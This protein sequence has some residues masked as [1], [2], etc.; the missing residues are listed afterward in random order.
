MLFIRLSVPQVIEISLY[1]DLRQS[2]KCPA[3]AQIL[4]TRVPQVNQSVCSFRMCRAHLF[5]LAKLPMHTM[6]MRLHLP[7]NIIALVLSCC[8]KQL[9]V[10][11]HR[12]CD[13]WSAKEYEF[14]MVAVTDDYNYGAGRAEDMALIRAFR[15][16]GRKATRVSIQ[17]DDFDWT[18]TKMV[19]IRSAWDKYDYYE[20]YV[21]FLQATDKRAILMNPLKVI[22]WQAEK[23]IYMQQLKDA[24]INTPDTVLVAQKD[25]EEDAANGDIEN[26]Q[27]K[28]GCEEVIIKPASGNA[29]IGVRLYPED[30]E[31]FLAQFRNII[32]NEDIA[33]FQ[34]YQE[35]IETKGER[36]IVFVGGEVSHGIM[37]EPAEDNYMVNTDYRRGMEHL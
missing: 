28:L 12:F 30:G 4:A 10:E 18:S 3:G 27:E 32:L 20:D 15:K 2:D 35:Q 31:M 1:L 16:L 6:K 23:D 11:G 34:C 19:V 26:I 33:I 24:G 29:G 9:M 17:D 13:L 22:Q 36:G 14:D 7:L 8:A 37:K 21:D 25:I 5:F